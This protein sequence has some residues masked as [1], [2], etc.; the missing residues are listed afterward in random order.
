LGIIDYLTGPWFAFSIFYLI[1][2][3]IVAWFVNRWAGILISIASVITWLIADL[4]WKMSYPN[5]AIPYW[6]AAMRLGLFLIVVFFMS[7]FRELNQ[8]LEER[9][10]ERTA[11]IE[12]EVAER[13][14][15]E[16][17]LRK[18]HEELEIQVQERTAELAKANEALRAEI[19]ERN[20]I[21]M[22]LR[23]SEERLRLVA[24]GVKDYAIFMLDTGGYVVSWN[25]GAEHIKG[26]KSEEIIGK[27]FSIFYPQEDIEYGKPQHNLDMAMRDGHYEDEGWRVRKDGSRFWANVV[28]TALRDE[29]G[30]LRGFSKVTRDITERKQMEEALKKAHSELEM[31]V[32]ERT[33]ELLKAR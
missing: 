20:Q 16:E 19:E 14:R 15:A 8:R 30:N 27:H 1:P 7:E 5:S 13:K 11:A 29:Y 33:A 10:A 24:E 31:R 23:E 28:I 21:E 4:V 25:A 9:V 6:N 17:A 2:V 12:G 32:H 18:A 26:H 22:V 3:S